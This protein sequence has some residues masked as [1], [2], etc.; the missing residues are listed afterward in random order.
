MIAMSTRILHTLVVLA[1]LG[2]C[3][4]GADADGE[5][6]FGGERAALA[7]ELA[8]M[9]I[10]DERVLAAMRRVP[11]HQFVPEDWRSRAYA[12]RALPI[13]EGQTIS[14]PYIVAYMTAALALEPD[15]KVLEI[16]TGS[17]Y[18]AAVLAE[19][20]GKVYSVEI[21]KPLGERARKTLDRLG[22][23]SVETRIGDGYRGWPD[24]APF[25]AIILTAAPPSVP[26]ALLQQLK[27]GGRMILPVGV[28]QQQLLL[29]HKQAD[30]TVRREDLLPVVFVP[31]TGGPE[32]P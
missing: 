21:V 28:D 12:N 8:E 24:Q 30:G 19:V 4:S 7:A 1:S 15:D 20:A 16:G 27:P 23:R 13:G 17:G 5:R 3:Q 6:D 31:M 9:G 32:R 26:K 22:Y 14:Q 10:T 18:Q 29:L 25:D 2:G 11:R